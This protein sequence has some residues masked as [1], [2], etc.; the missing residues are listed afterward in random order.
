MLER[1]LQTW[2]E[3]SVTV[4]EVFLRFQKDNAG[5]RAKFLRRRPEETPKPSYILSLTPHSHGIDAEERFL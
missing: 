3:T 2:K 1:R 4:L 5:G